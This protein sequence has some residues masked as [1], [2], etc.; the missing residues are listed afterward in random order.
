MS[1]EQ[2]LWEP[3]RKA[4]KEARL[5]L[6]ECER[7]DSKGYGVYVM[8]SHNDMRRALIAAVRVDKVMK[9]ERKR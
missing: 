4:V 2:E 5:N 8:P 9:V 6:A 3:S 1:N 7:V